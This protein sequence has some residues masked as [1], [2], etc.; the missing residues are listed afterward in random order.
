MA[1]QLMSSRNGDAVLA[2][3]APGQGAQKSGFLA[4]WLNDQAVAE[5]IEVCSAA[6]GRNL[7]AA[8]TWMPDEAITDTAVAQPLIVAAAMAAVTRLGLPHC[9]VLAGLSIGEFT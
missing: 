4:P 7:A 2:V 1:A 8:G 9:T 5:R 6:T 3:V